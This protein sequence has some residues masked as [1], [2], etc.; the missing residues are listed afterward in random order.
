M[1][2]PKVSV[3]IPT[4]NRSE[5]I[6]RSI[7]SVKRQTYDNLE[8][9]VVDDGSTDDTQ[10]LL[11]DLDNIQ[12]IFQANKGV[13]CARN[14]GIEKATGDYIAFLDSD[15]EWLAQKVELQI[16]FLENSKAFKWIHTEE[17][18]IRNGVSVNQMKKHKKG[19]G[20][21]F[22]PSLNLCLISP[23]SVLIEKSLLGK[24]SFRED[25]EVCEDYDLWL[26]LLKDNPIAFIEEPLIKKYGG[27]EDQLSRKYF[28]MDLYRVKSLVEIR[29]SQG[30]SQ[31]QLQ[32]IKEVITKKSE[33]LL[34]GALKHNNR[35]MIEELEELGIICK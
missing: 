2:T 22:L 14:L 19:G 13:S 30:L 6:L 11:E 4:F 25:F 32:K 21:Q 20:D 29:K 9:I 28:G 34:K 5:T 35:K 10:N 18:W 3:I 23:S 33:V 8:I 7:E 1:S 27:H 31:V 15:D 16:A 12:Y 17:I 26:R 24:N